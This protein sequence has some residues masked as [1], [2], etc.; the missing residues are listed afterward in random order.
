MRKALVLEALGVGERVCVP[1]CKPAGDDELRVDERA[2]DT[3]RDEHRCARDELGGL[4]RGTRAV[5]AQAR[6]LVGD[7]LAVARLALEEE[8]ELQ[9]VA[10][11]QGSLPR[12]SRR[13]AL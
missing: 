2:Q 13:V 3:V 8:L 6:G 4:A 12:R 11:I 5:P 10:Q 9:E 1:R 7:L